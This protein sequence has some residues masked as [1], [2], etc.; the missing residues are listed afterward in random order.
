VDVFPGG[1]YEVDWLGYVVEEGYPYLHLEKLGRSIVYRIN[2]NSFMIYTDPVGWLWTNPNAYPWI[3]SV[4]YQ[5][6]FYL[7]DTGGQTQQ[8]WVFCPE[9]VEGYLWFPLEWLP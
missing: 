9:G 3:Y 6:W 5:T 7:I 1:H 4:K 2:A 8:R